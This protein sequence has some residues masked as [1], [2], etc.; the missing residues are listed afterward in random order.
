M[1]NLLTGIGWNYK[2]NGENVKALEYYEK[3][4]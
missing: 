2:E 3:A 1:A 4:H